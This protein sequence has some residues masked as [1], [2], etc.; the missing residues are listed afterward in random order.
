M[1][2][3]T[4]ATTPVRSHQSMTIVVGDDAMISVGHFTDHPNIGSYHLILNS[5]ADIYLS[6]S[7]ARALVRELGYAIDAAQD[8]DA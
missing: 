7:S 5:G 2:T 3:T 8:G 6:E 4:E 1:T